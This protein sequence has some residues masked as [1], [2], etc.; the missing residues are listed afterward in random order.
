MLEKIQ[1]K[2]FTFG[3]QVFTIRSNANDLS[4]RFLR[5]QGVMK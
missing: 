5:T 1:L 3:A 2:N 4:V